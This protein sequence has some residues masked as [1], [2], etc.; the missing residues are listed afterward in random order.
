[1]AAI[2]RPGRFGYNRPP[3]DAVL[4]G[5]LQERMRRA[6]EIVRGLG[7]AAVAFSGGVDS[8]LVLK[9]CR[10]ELGDRAVAVTARSASFAPE[11]MADAM[12]IAREI[13]ARQLFV[14]TEEITLKGYAENPVTRCFHCKSE[15]YD[16]L[17]AVAAR[18]GL[19]AV[20]DGVNA[21]DVEGGDRRPGIAAGLRHGVV[22]PL[23]DAGLSKEDVRAAARALG[24]SA[25]DKPAMACLSSRIPFGEPITEE[26][27]AQVAA[28][29]GALRKLGLAGARV[30]HHGAIARLELPPDRLAAA[31][32]PATRA[33][34]VAGV[35]A[36]GFA[37]VALDLEGY[38]AGSMHEVLSIKP[39]ARPTSG[40]GA[41]TGTK[42]AGK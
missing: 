10:D 33:A 25:W 42:G 27:L 36:A 30:R 26:K 3:M 32:E 4:S 17:G 13:G 9:L 24:I 20:V 31:L 40:G 18:E 2:A 11:E 14:D 8:A 38:R 28:A 6:R 1:M 41:S 35:R 22:S 7:S 16:K 23:R 39:A 15:L 5:P 34:I 19:E 37:Y 21:D 29:E 12:R